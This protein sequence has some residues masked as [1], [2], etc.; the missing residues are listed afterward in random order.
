M[1][2][3]LLI[4]MQAAPTSERFSVLVDPCASVA[5]G[6]DEVVVCAPVAPAPRLP[7]PAERGPPDRP[8]ASNPEVTG[9]GAMAAAASPCATL[10]QG[11]GSSVDV[12]G[13]GVFLVRAVGKLVD[14]DS[15]CEEAGEYKDPGALLRDVGRLFK[16]GPGKADR[17]K[18]VAIPLD[19]ATPMAM[20]AP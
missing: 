3:L 18:R 17:A 9:R 4:A 11:C 14:P 7:L 15:C 13:G 16:R 8:M 12:I 10:S 6:E 5:T 20:P 1:L 19:P 2:A